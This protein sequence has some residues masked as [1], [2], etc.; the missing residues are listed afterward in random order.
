MA[1]HYNR[2]GDVIKFKQSDNNSYDMVRGQLTKYAYGKLKDWQLAEDAVQDSYLRLLKYPPQGE[3]K[4][5]AGI[6][7]IT[8]DRAI[9]R[10]ISIEMKKGAVIEE[11]DLTDE[12]ESVIER[13]ASDELTPDKV[14]EIEGM[15]NFVMDKSDKL[16]PK[17]KAIVRLSLIFNYSYK[18]VCGITGAD[19]KTIDNVLSYFRKKIK[20]V[21]ATNQ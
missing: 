19:V 17:K 4:Y 11:E 21:A 12:D 5:F 7:K 8:L 6:F 13:A 2:H 14:L 9:A 18:E 3:E 16:P 10:I 15:V 20:D 1:K